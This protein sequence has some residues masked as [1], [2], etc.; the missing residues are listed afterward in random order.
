MHCDIVFLYRIL[1]LFVFVGLHQ[2]LAI[3]SEHDDILSAFVH[4]SLEFAV[5]VGKM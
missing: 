1:V 3:V 4:H 5:I 2:D